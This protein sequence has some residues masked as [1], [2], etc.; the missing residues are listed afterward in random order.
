MGENSL[1]LLEEKVKKIVGL[2]SRL[3]ED[4][5]RFERERELI[6]G[7][8]DELLKRIREVIDGKR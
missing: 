2:V 4:K 7:K 5:K 8:V 6:G 1:S 3:R